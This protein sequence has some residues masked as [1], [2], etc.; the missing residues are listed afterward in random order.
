MNS[1]C[2]ECAS[3]KQWDAINGKC[4]DCGFELVGEDKKLHDANVELARIMGAEFK[5][6]DRRI[7]SLRDYDAPYDYPSSADKAAP[8]ADVPVAATFLSALRRK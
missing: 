5:R 7:R 6:E 4:F 1:Y 2:P 3:E 8:T